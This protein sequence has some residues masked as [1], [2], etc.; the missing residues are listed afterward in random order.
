MEEWRHLMAEQL[1]T[2]KTNLAI[3]MNIYKS[4]RHL[5]IHTCPR[6]KLWDLIYRRHVLY[7]GINF[8]SYI[9]DSCL[10]FHVTVSSIQKPICYDNKNSKDQENKYWKVRGLSIHGKVTINKAFLLSKM[11]YPSSVLTTPPE[12]IKEFKTKSDR[13]WSNFRL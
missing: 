2:A 1:E 9:Q 8:L 3:M 5:I 7:S 10:P 12:I 11:I 6:K 4:K 13:R